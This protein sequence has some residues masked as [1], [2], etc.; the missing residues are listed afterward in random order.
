MVKTQG[1]THP[2]QPP[3]HQYH[4]R[5]TTTTATQTHT[6]HTHI[7]T[8]TSLME[9]PWPS[10][11]AANV[12]VSASTASNSPFLPASSSRG[13]PVAASSDQAHTKNSSAACLGVWVGGGP[14]MMYGWHMA[15]GSSSGQRD[16]GI[17]MIEQRR[18]QKQKQTPA[19]A[20]AA[21]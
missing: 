20:A 16:N 3:A 7:R 6:A 12:A 15:A 2:L 5:H 10:R 14:C 1:H 9:E 21:P 8:A 17:G 13:A 19:V 4:H 11:Q 18:Q